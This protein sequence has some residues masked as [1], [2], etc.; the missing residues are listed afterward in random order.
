MTLY[1]QFPFLRIGAGIL[2]G[3]LIEH[4]QSMGTLFWL[5]INSLSIAILLRYKWMRMEVKW[6]YRFLAGTCLHVILISTGAFSFTEDSKRNYP[7]IQM[8]NK[9]WILVHLTSEPMQTRTGFRYTAAIYDA[10]ISQKAFAGNCFLYLKGVETACYKQN[11]ILLC[12]NKLKL[13]KPGT[14]PFA[15][16][17]Y[18]YAKRNKVKYTLHLDSLQLIKIGQVNSKEFLSTSRLRDYFLQTLRK[19]IPDQKICGLAEAMLTGYREDLDKELLKAYTNTGV[20][21]IIAISGLHLGLIFWLANFLLQKIIPHKWLPAISLTTVLP[22]LWIFSIMTGSSASV[23]RSVIMFS[24]S[25]TANALAKR[26][27]N[28]NAL[29]A[30]GVLLLLY[31]PSYVFDIGFQLSY[32]A[33]ASILLFEKKIRNV[34]FFK[35]KAA[36]Y[37]WSMVSITIAA[38]I[39][40][41]PFVIYHFHR[42]PLLF[43]FSNLIA[44]PLSSIILLLEIL[45]CLLD[46][47]G[48]GA[49]ITGELIDFL[50]TCMN[51]FVMTM[52]TIPFNLVDNI[53]LSGFSTVMYSILIISLL[54]LMYNI[55]IISNFYIMI[56]PLVCVI[57]INAEHTIKPMKKDWTVLHISGTT[58][59]IH[60]HG[61]SIRIFYKKNGNEKPSEI[62]LKLQNAVNHLQPKEIFWQSLPE[63]PFILKINCQKQL[64]AA[65]VLLLSGISE[66][67]LNNLT[68]FVTEGTHVIADGTHKLWKIKEWEKEAHELN[69]RFLST[70]FTGSV[71]IDCH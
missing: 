65:P 54:Y 48:T 20:V 2:T 62:R 21:H 8:Q 67:R 1:R 12:S 50:T 19:Y 63:F 17:F 42:F 58:C 52:H 64:Q 26:N 11:D 69:L 13:L 3:I 32:A 28:M 6:K 47:I 46:S 36:L 35:N 33:V 14:D 5:I 39:L 4:Y 56:I 16:D 44:V 29:L 24:L 66:L 71:T 30:S 27:N 61:K 15:F 31:D 34:F 70:S 57:L 60:R 23:L 55:K 68:G 49:E 53:Y 22:M 59:I 25:I 18:T 40:T 43:L 51:N 9:E 41:T 7:E 45:L 10:V 38:Q 37:G